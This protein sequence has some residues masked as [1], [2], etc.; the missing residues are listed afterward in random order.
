MAGRSLPLEI[1]EDCWIAAK[2]TVFQDCHIGN[3]SV[4]GTGSLVNS[5]IPPDSIAV[6]TPARV[7][8]NLLKK[9]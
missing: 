9:E 7:V 4:I 6:G 3:H 2:V 5:P 8:K 1:G